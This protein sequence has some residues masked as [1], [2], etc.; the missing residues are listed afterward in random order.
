VLNFI[1]VNTRVSISISAPAITYLLVLYGCQ[2]WSG[3]LR[4]EHKQR[5]FGNRVLRKILVPKG[6][7]VTGDCKKSR[8]EDKHYRYSSAN[9]IRVIESRTMRWAGRVAPVGERRGVCMISVGKPTK[10]RLLGRP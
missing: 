1:L 2:T 10:E 3:T 6:A 5:L 4:A 8:Y 7:D 9:I